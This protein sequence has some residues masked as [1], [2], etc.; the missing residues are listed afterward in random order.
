MI[1]DYIFVLKDADNQFIRLANSLDQGNSGLNLWFETKDGGEWLVADKDYTLKVNEFNHIALVMD[2]GTV[3][4]YLNGQNIVSGYFNNLTTSLNDAVF[5]VGKDTIYDY[6][7]FEGIFQDFKIM[8]EAMS[9]EEIDDLFMSFYPEVLLERI[10]FDYMDDLVENFWL[11]PEVDN[12]YPA[13]WTSS[14]TAFIDIQNNRSVITLPTVEQGDQVVSLSIQTTINNQTYR[15]D[16]DFTLRCESS[17]TYVYRDVKALK[18]DMG[19]ILDEG[20]ELASLTENGSVISWTAIS[21]EVAIDS[22]IL[23]KLS[24]EDKV[25]YTLQATISN[26]D[27]SEQVLFEGIL[28]DSYTGYIM[29]YFNGDLE[30]EKGK[31]AYSYDGLNWINLD[32]FTLS[33]SLG[34]GRV[35]DP[36]INRDKDGNFTI[37]ATEGYDNPEIYIWH[38]EDLIDLSNHSLQTIA[39]YI[40][41]I[42]STGNRA[43]APEFYYDDENDMYYIYYSDPENNGSIYYVT[44]SDFVD[45]SYPDTFFGPGYSVIDATIITMNGKYYLFYKDERDGAKTIFYSTTDSLDS[46]FSVAYDENFL[47]T[48]KYV[49]GPFVV[50]ALDNGTYYLYVDNYYNEI[51][52]VGAFSELSETSTI[53][54]LD[55][56]DYTLPS[57]DV[58]HGSVITVTEDEL[59]RLIEAYQ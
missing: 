19:Y 43:W 20:Y 2:N 26:Q 29:M 40:P 17:E 27:V 32:N 28:L 39:Y 9:D 56:E 5:T 7:H 59:N 33:S 30:N 14:D 18:V 50:K 55:S 48:K 8:N 52:Y 21:G 6:H 34:N 49:E 3:S 22:G 51:F 24:D 53:E 15:K 13:T 25:P 47:F 42:K 44:T 10:T 57:D 37:L 31:M 46:L 23:Y 35:R 12:T 38:S 4:L 54:W 58:R 36:F 45:F 16:F 1:D 41:S 11:Y